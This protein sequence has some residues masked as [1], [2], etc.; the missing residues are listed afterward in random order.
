VTWLY[1]PGPAAPEPAVSRLPKQPR[2][3][4]RAGAHRH[5]PRRRTRNGS[6]YSCVVADREARRPAA[7]PAAAARADPGG[8]PGPAGPAAGGPAGSKAGVVAH[9]VPVSHRGGQLVVERARS[10]SSAAGPGGPAGPGN[11]ARWR[12]PANPGCAP[13]RGRAQTRSARCQA[14]GVVTYRVRGHRPRLPGRAATR[15]GAAPGGGR[16]AGEARKRQ[17]QPGGGSTGRV[18]PA[19]AGRRRTRPRS[20]GF[21]ARTAAGVEQFVVAQGRGP[22]GPRPSL[23]SPSFPRHPGPASGNRS[24]GSR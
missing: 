6:V 18:R 15:T 11:A 21:T 4:R 24:G 7:G 20:P 17:G 8:P 9:R 5:L 19:E 22:A 14:P 2:G 1:T 13:R 3:P 23:S 10:A 12:G 16:P